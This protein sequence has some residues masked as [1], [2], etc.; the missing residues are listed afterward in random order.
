MKNLL[1]LELLEVTASAS[2]VEIHKNV[3][4]WNNNTNYIK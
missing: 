1:T 2:D 4:V 3:G